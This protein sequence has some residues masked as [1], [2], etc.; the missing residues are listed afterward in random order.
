MR[1]E[2]MPAQP[3][4]IQWTSAFEEA[5]QRAKTDGRDVLLDFSAAPM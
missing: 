3:A 2:N 5:L 1:G 4:N